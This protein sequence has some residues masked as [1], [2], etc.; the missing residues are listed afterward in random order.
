MASTV[1][2]CAR[3]WQRSL[4]Y[5]A[6]GHAVWRAQG[7]PA[8]DAVPG[9][10]ARDR[11]HHP[12]L[13]R[14]LRR[15]EVRYQDDSRQIRTQAGTHDG[16]GSRMTF[17]LLLQMFPI[18]LMFSAP[19][20]L[21]ALGGLF[22]ERSGIVNIALEGIMKVGHFTGATVTVCSKLNAQRHGTAYSGHWRRCLQHSGLRWRVSTSRLTMSFQVPALNILSAASR[23]ISSNYLPSSRTRDSQCQTRN[24]AAGLTRDS[25]L[26]RM[27]FKEIYPTF[28]SRLQWFHLCLWLQTLAGAA[29]RACAN[30][31]GRAS[32]GINVARCAF[33]CACI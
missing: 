22:S 31:P 14:A 20:I 9:D 3:R 1:L 30:S 23:Y 25:V 29:H 19:I 6:C 28:T 33:R 7:R 21:T 2:R 12:G 5:S 13:H 11:G 24:S 32:M 26:G 15:D 16:R 8:A 17:E 27:F 4:S 10:S 18:A